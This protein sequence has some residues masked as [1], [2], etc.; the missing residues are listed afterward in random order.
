[1]NNASQQALSTQTVHSEQSI[2]S[3]LA[4]NDLEQNPAG[5]ISSLAPKILTDP[6][7]LA[8]I[9]PYLDALKQTID[10]PG[11]TNIALTG[12]YG[13]GKSTI[14]NTFQAMH[15]EYRYLRISLASFGEVKDEA[16]KT[17][18]QIA[19]GAAAVKVAKD[20]KEELE[21]LL[22]VSILQQIFYHVKPSQIPDSRFKRITNI[23]EPW[24]IKFSIGLIL[25]VVSCLFLF[26][27]NYIDRIDPAGWA[28]KLPI[29][30]ITIVSVPVF[31][32]GIAYFTRSIIRL[33]GNS[34]INKVNIKGELE[35]GD[36]LDKS[37]FNEHL[38]EILYFF[39]RTEF[40][41]VVIE[42]L[43]RFDSTEI[44]TKLREL[45]TLLNNSVSI[46][47]RKDHKEIV[48][49][50]AI[51]DEMFIDKNERVKFFEYIIP[52]I[53]FINPSNAGEQLTKLIDKAGLKG[54]LTH[55]FTQDV[56]TFID[57]IDM[58]LLINIFHEYQLYRSSLGPGLSQDHLFAMITYKNMFPDDFGKLH[59]RKGN[60]YQFLSSRE[61]YLKSLVNDVN[62]R[63]SALNTTISQI[64]S[65][66]EISVTELRAIY[67]NALHIRFP[68]ATA[69]HVGGRTSFAELYDEDNF[70]EL[71]ALEDIN[72]YFY[73][74]E[75]YYGR[76]F[77]E[78]QTASS[79]AFSSI[80]KDVDEKFTYLE[81]VKQIADRQ[82]HK[83]NE[84]R[85]Q[86]DVLQGKKQALE[87]LS[88]AEIFEQVDI[89]P[90][91]S[92]FSESGLMRNL[93]LNGYINES[94]SDY[95]SLFH[96][97]NL[98]HNDFI[99][100]K[101]VKSGKNSAFAFK[102]DKIEN[103]VR[104]LSPKYFE[105][106]VILNFD[107]IGFLLI[108]SKA[109]SEKAKLVFK[110][111]ASEKTRTIEF[112]DGLVFSRHRIRGI[113]IEQLLTNWKAMWRYLQ[114]QSNYPEKKLQ[115]Y[116]SLIC[117]HG[118]VEDLVA[119][120]P[121]LV[122]YIA[123][124]PELLM[125]MERM[126][127]I[128]KAKALLQTIKPRF[129]SLNAPDPARQALFEYVYENGLYVLNPHNIELLLRNKLPELN[130]EAIRTQNYTVV[131]ESGLQALK[132]YAN[133][134]I[135]SYVK[136][137]LMKL[138][139]SNESETH[140]LSLLNHEKIEQ[141]YKIALLKN[142]ETKLQDLI[143]VG[144]LE[145]RQA[146]IK[147]EKIVSDWR[148]ICTYF[149]TIA[150]EENQIQFDELIL[151]YLN[152]PEVYHAL[153]AQQISNVEGRDEPYKKALNVALLT[154]NELQTEA[155]QILMKS[156]SYRWTSIGFETLFRD[157]IEFLIEK[158]YLRISVSN[159]DK[160]K[161]NFGTLHIRLILLNQNDFAEKFSEI[162]LDDDDKVSLLASPSLRIE[163]RYRIVINLTDETLVGDGNL[164][165][166]ACEV[167]SDQGKTE[168]SYTALLSMM[169]HNRSDEQRI[170]LL[171]KH[172]DDL[173]EI[174]VQALVEALGGD[175]P[176]CFIKR[177]RPRF[178]NTDYRRTLF[179]WLKTKGLIHEMKEVKGDAQR[180]QVQA[181]Y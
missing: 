94:Y 81:R 121:E 36:K 120:G 8:K 28:L 60:L 47:E 177:H 137:V 55:E 82:D 71:L 181:C 125:V 173:E 56:V 150:E 13:S 58:R 101:N 46:K 14:I 106:E 44:F 24:I 149:D 142:M 175:Y 147:Q 107:L 156:C 162:T 140:L 92:I 145:L 11:I 33:L 83:V 45:N 2:Q 123:Q 159:F 118:A 53:P 42:D 23:T 1:M 75:P 37:V 49:L 22:E 4:T 72:Y 119:Q 172:L 20:K 108:E 167:L 174:E 115:T 29:S 69:I 48:F 111:L 7:E 21:R 112:I 32:G 126:G 51:R 138:P 77:A 160:L 64:E 170:K 99:F 98:S 122:S 88:L 50:Y 139:T 93:L 12:G 128:E 143:K 104:A 148:N 3:D 110:Q 5:P 79:T 57:D 25:W 18:E 10:A 163:L 16:E 178:A 80:E 17:A 129:E 136:N 66:S 65:A 78:I 63:I 135:N 38:E 168:L 155:Y 124:H 180:L 132:T 95:I 105:R 109:T 84:R 158:F 30:W 131:M 41:L 116:L 113:F 96:A 100:E 161:K 151:E 153:S 87:G 34:K 76:G 54:I 133:S 157:K 117:R 9:K 86:I 171:N 52:V 144:N 127:A 154:C 6:Q 176:E 146:L 67:I 26:K 19:G 27:F 102:L 134:E 114:S 15:E 43:D 130:D 35:L 62:Q 68:I 103:L 39:E 165:R 59:S 89:T 152:K 74:P 73:T 91:L 97:V 70:N 90:H 85:A 141:G 169:E 61:V 40:N 166:L 179:T 164:A 31:F